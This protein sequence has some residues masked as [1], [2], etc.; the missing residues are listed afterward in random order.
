[1]LF[2]AGTFRLLL[3]TTH[4]PLSG[5]FKEITTDLIMHKVEFA[6]RFLKSGW[7]IE[8]PKILICGLNPHAGE[9]GWLGKEEE[10]V[11]K[12]ALALLSE[13]GLNVSGP[14]S[15]DTAYRIY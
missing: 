15:A 6:G 10:T 8:N 7:G 14:V 5:V 2:S 9:G 12:P 3:L 4:L 1:M 13:E 11:F